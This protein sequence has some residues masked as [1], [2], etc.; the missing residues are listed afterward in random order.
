MRN[1]SLLLRA[2]VIVAVAATQFAMPV[3]AQEVAFKPL[4]DARLRYETVEQ[5]GPAPITK[6]RDANA[7]TLRLRMGGELS[8]GHWS[9]LAEAQGTLAI[10]KDYNAFPFA[11]TNSQR[12]TQYPVVADPENIDLNRLQLQ[13]KSQAVT[14]TI[15][16]QRINLDDQRFVGS[17]GWRQNEQTFDAVRVEAK[18]GPVMVDGTYAISQR[19]IYGIEAKQRQAYGGDFIFLQA[20]VK[21]GP[22]TVKGFAYILDYDEGFFFTNSSQT[23]GARAVAVLPLSRTIKWTLTGSYARQ[24]DYGLNPVRYA[25]DY[26]LAEA[27][28]DYRGFKLTGGYE[29]LGSDGRANF[30]FQTPMATLHK[31]NG[32]ADKFLTTPNT[33]LQDY[34][35]GIGYSWPKVGN[36]GPLIAGFTFHRFDSDRA[37]IHYGDEYNA[38]VSLKLNK[39][40][41]ALVKY[42]DYERQGI[43]SFAGD[44]DTRKVWAEIDFAL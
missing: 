6:D 44:A 20:G 16:R 28:V 1:T 27:A 22:V 25:A 42:A 5:D 7:V 21:Q 38:Q 8:L 23:Y 19:S 37:N 9:A 41:T 34:Y 3:V 15:G 29:L 33:G 14:A 32:W 24:S 12:R 11:V 43:A 2:S 26:V 30:A 10:D 39:Q 40:L 17:V 36:M 35:A 18:A 4:V 31:F 13:Y